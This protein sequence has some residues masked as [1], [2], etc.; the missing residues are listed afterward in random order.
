MAILLGFLGLYNT[1]II[2]YKFCMVKKKQNLNKTW[3]AKN[4]EWNPEKDSLYIQQLKFGLFLIKQRQK[5][6]ERK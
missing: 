2:S 4:V 5:N 3:I 1:T 6:R